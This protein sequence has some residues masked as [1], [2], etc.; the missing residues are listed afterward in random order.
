MSIRRLD[1][2]LPPRTKISQLNEMILQ[3]NGMVEQ[4]RFNKKE[5]DSIYDT[6]VSS[7]KYTREV[8]LGSTVATYTGWSHL[9]AESGYSIWKYTPTSYT[10][11]SNNRLYMNDIVFENRGSALSETATA[12]DTVFLW[13]GDSGSGYLDRTT[14]AGTPLGTAFEVMN[15]KHDYLYLG[16]STTFSGVKFNW[17]TRGSNYTLKADYW[18]G[19]EWLELT[20]NSNTLEDG[21]NDFQ[22]NGHLSYD[23]PSNWATTSVNSVSKYWLRISSTTDPITVAE[24]YYIIPANNVIGLLALSSTELLNEEWAWCAYNGSIYVTLRNIGASSTEGS[25]FVNS[26]SSTANKENFFVHNN[27]F[28]AD[29]ESS[30][31]DP[32]KEF[33][34]TSS[35]LTTDG[36]VLA[37]AHISSITLTLPAAH[38]TEGMEFIIKKV[39]SGNTVTVET[40]SGETIDGAGNKVLSTQYSFL[41]V[42][43]DAGNWYIIGGGGL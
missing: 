15:T 5:L 37:S 20:T 6:I 13:N 4:G 23:I 34:T 18:T 21:T 10:H 2:D 24:F 25:Y 8:A 3:L 41:R 42:V 26:S 30:L 7:R 16:L 29:Y 43:S 38:T 36:I 22:S 35:I 14:E 11:S 1:A 19:S 39:N 27:P 40:L 12:F 31:Y 28:T 9:Y 33:T 17:N 32:V